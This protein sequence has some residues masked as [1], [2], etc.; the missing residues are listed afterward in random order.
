MHNRV[1]TLTHV[2]R[3][4]HQKCVGI[5]ITNTIRSWQG[6]DG[7]NQLGTDRGTGELRAQ[8]FK[9]VI[10][11][12]ATHTEG[13]SGDRR[14][15]APLRECKSGFC[16]RQE[17]V[18]PHIGFRG[19]SYFLNETDR[20][21]IVG[22]VVK[23]LIVDYK[24]EIG[25]VLSAV[26]NVVAESPLYKSKIAYHDNKFQ[27]AAGTRQIRGRN[28]NTWE[29]QIFMQNAFLGVEYE[30]LIINWQAKVLNNHVRPPTVAQEL[31]GDQMIT[32]WQYG[33]DSKAS[34]PAKE[35]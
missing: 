16:A 23:P 33:A 29:E 34:Y 27:F 21:T 31:L 25:K 2:L 19:R 14:N 1:L 11:F 5:G 28:K 22:G 4:Y 8:P 15:W 12:Q 30:G 32:S 18:V 6:D 17:H 7:W 20:T 35:W 9:D 10:G 3:I 24:A 26:E 13:H